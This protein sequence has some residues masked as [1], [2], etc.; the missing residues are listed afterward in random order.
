MNISAWF[1]FEWGIKEGYGDPKIQV[2]TINDETGSGKQ[3]ISTWSMGGIKPKWL[4]VA[5]GM[6]K[7]ALFNA[8]IYNEKK[9]VQES[10]DDSGEEERK[11]QEEE[12]KAERERLREEMKRLKAK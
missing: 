6:G 9:E 5:S 8:Y 10:S 4:M 11:R 3:V 1:Q 12:I 2:S 7:T